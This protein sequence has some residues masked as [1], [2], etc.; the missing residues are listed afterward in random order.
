MLEYKALDLLEWIGLRKENGRPDQSMYVC[1]SIDAFACSSP[2]KPERS[3]A[4]NSMLRGG[5]AVLSKSDN[6]YPAG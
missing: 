4:G 5:L 6:C 1:L 3:R 2:G